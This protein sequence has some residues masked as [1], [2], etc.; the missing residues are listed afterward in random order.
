MRSADPFAE[1][2][3]E[4]LRRAQAGSLEA[5]YNVGRYYRDG[6][7]AVADPVAAAESFFRAAEQGHA[8]AG[9]DLRRLL[10]DGSAAEHRDWGIQE[11]WFELECEAAE[12]GEPDAQFV[13]SGMYRQ[14]VGTERD[15]QEATRWAGAAADGGLAEA[16]V[17]HSL[18][19]AERGRPAS[20]R[21]RTD[22]RGI[23]QQLSQGDRWWLRWQRSDAELR[24]QEEEAWLKAASSGHAG[25]QFC[26]GRLCAEERDWGSADA[27]AVRWLRIAAE[28][29]H[30]GA[31]C[32]LGCMYAE[33]RGVPKDGGRAE[34]WW[35]RA[36]ELGNV[37]AQCL[38]GWWPF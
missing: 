18:L 34:H 22:T 23:R 6:L 37:K 31:G 8:K 16:K 7:G 15:L 2:L 32:Q 30:H 12:R 17:E 27:Q 25:A 33:G 19:L 24:Q 3:E 26:L 14:R 29:G 28:R 35:S 9:A 36:A 21:G 1:Q 20:G 10:R 4:M 13:V 11:W 38:L 5:Q